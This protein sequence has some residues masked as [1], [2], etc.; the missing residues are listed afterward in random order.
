MRVVRTV[1]GMQRLAVALKRE[2]FL[3][4]VPTMGGLHEGHLDLV[5]IAR[6]RCQRVVVS[7]FVNPAQFGSGEDFARYP[8]NLRRDCRLI[9]SVGADAVF[10]PSVEQMYPRGHATHVDV[11]RLTMHL[12]GASRP[13]HFQG[14]ATV[15]AKLLNIVQPDV[16]VF[17][18]KDAQ[19]ALVIRRMV[20][21]LNMPV[22][23]IVAPTRREKD[24]LAMSSRNAY[25]SASDRAAAPALYKSLRLARRLVTRGERDARVIRAEVRRYI[26]ARTRG[27]L[28]YVEIVDRAELTPVKTI[29]GDVLVALAVYFGKTRLIDNVTV[30]P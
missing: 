14:V 29:E 30:R 27:R 9:E 17:G 23:V 3:G 28:D 24:G 7:V 2:G 6:R 5:R 19:Q 21:D 20:F 10:A 11:E 13:G 12:C 8:R 15:V 22:R 4:L 25:L 18:R 1:A 26:R 16:A